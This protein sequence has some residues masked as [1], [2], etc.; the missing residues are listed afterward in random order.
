[1][2]KESENSV[3]GYQHKGLLMADV[4]EGELFT[5]K[6]VAAWAKITVAMVRAMINRGELPAIRLG[7]LWRVSRDDLDVFLTRQKSSPP[8]PPLDASET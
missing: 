3:N 5:L 2:A 6:E 4:P 1:M 8:A 7:R